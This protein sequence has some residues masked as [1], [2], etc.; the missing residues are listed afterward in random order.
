MSN[1]SQAKDLFNKAKKAAID[2]VEKAKKAAAEN[3]DKVRGGI[4]KV[5]DAANKVTKGKYA[6]KINAAGDKVE[7]TVQKGANSKPVG[8]ASTGRAPGEVPDPI[9]TP[10]PIDRPGPVN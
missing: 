1:P 2:G 8:G 3:P 6:D 7:E 4:D 10:D 9:D 5:T